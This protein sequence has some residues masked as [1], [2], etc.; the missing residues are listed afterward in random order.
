MCMT[1][2]RIAFKDVKRAELESFKVPPLAN[3]SVLIETEYSV[4][5]A[6]TERA[7]LLA[8][9]NTEGR[10]PFIPVTAPLAG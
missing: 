9:P 6:G 10:F 4:I 3:G 7:N 2:Y 1:G 5:S 8:M